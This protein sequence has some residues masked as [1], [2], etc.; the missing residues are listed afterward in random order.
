MVL[1]KGG[2]MRGLLLLGLLFGDQTLERTI[3]LSG[4]GWGKVQVLPVEADGLAHTRE[5]LV[6]RLDAADAP[7]AYRVVVERPGGYCAGG[8]FLP[9]T[10]T[11]MP[12]SWETAELIQDR[13]IHK[14]LVVERWGF[15]THG[16]RVTL[17]TLD[18]PRC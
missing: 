17:I 12:L 13:G 4:L 10:P 9:R 8:W 14:F 1:T 3:D 16:M 11:P 5:W 18:L 6:T 2:E 15:F 7:E